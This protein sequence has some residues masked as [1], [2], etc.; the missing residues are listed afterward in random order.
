[1]ISTFLV[2]HVKQIARL[3]RELGIIRSLIVLFLSAI[4]LARMYT[5]EPPYTYV[6][7]A[8]LF[9]LLLSFHTF[10]QDKTFLAIIGVR[11]RLLYLVE[12]H[13]LVSPVYL[14]FLLNGRWIE[15]VSTG[16]AVSLLPFIHLR[17]THQ[18]RVASR[19]PFIF[20]EAFEWKSGLR[21]QG[22]L[23]G[24]LYVAALGL[25]PYPFVALLVIVVF[26]FVVTT[27]YNESE[28][29]SMVEAFASS[30]SKFLLRK[31]KTQLTLFWIGCAPLVLIFLL[32][33]ATYWYV[34]LV[35]VVVCSVIQLLSIHLKYSLYEPNVTL[36][37]DV[38]MFIYFLSLFVPFFFPVPLVMM[39]HYYR[40][41]QKNL[42]PYL[43][44]S[45]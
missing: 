15:T 11:S 29:R 38:F 23:I 43:H 39:I 37:K 45:L 26:T 30:P 25:Y 40:R 36:N 14:I 13:L 19:L 4:T 17:L 10:R 34:L 6:I 31:G 5:L 16:A 32:T 9:F 28:P 7:A 35:W 1:M 22:W 8:L 3:S 27:F 42:K 2:L 33:N 12:Y 41:A 21:K 44:D 18:A 20:P 24:S